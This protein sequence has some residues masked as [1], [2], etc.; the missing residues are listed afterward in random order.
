M[1]K[2]HPNHKVDNLSFQTSIINKSHERADKWA[3]DLLRLLSISIDLVA[4]DA[5]YDGKCESDFLTKKFI[6]T[7]KETE[8]E[9]TSGRRADNAMKSNFEKLCKWLDEQTELFTVSELHA[10]MCS[11]YIKIFTL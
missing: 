5:I 9:H 1:D 10:K 4:S 3:D 7:T 11:F 6:P 2:K 8:T